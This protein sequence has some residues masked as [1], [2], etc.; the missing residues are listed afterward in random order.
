MFQHALPNSV[1]V[2]HH[3]FVARLK[4]D[5]SEAAC[6]AQQNSRTEQ[7]CQAVNYNRKAKGSPLTVGD[8]VLLANRGE[9]G[10]RLLLPVSFLPAGGDDTLESSC[11][12]VAGSGQCDSVVPVDIQDNE[13]KTINWLLQI[14]DASDRDTTANQPAYSPDVAG[15]C[16]PSEIE[17]SV[18]PHTLSELLD[19]SDFS[20]CAAQLLSRGPAAEYVV[21]QDGPSHSLA[22]EAH[23]VPRTCY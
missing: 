2:D 18:V 23:R 22:E 3:E 13:T 10:K 19:A 16:L 1:V 4:H 6:I 12:S 17:E 11:S 8:R 9:R 5:L 14:E 21:S 7:A 15:G 20:A